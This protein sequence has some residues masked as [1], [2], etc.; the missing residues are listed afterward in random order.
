DQ[1]RAG[2]DFAALA[3][4]ESDGATASQGGS[5]ELTTQGSYKV[6]AVDEALF[7]LPVGTISQLIEG[8]EGW[9]LVRVDEKIAAGEVSFVD[10]QEDIRKAIREDKLRKESQRYV[11]EL[12]RKAHITPIFDRPSPGSR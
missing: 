12:A 6:S 5:W 11:Q 4:A 1:L 9:H 2:A 7:R 8:P 3:K 10:A